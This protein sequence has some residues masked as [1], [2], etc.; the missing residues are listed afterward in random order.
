MFEELRDLVY[1]QFAQECKYWAKTFNVV[2]YDCVDAGKKYL[3]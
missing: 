1:Q 3:K 2:Y